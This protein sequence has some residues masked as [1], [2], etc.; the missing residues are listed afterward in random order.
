MHVRDNQQLQLTL[1]AGQAEEGCPWALCGVCTPQGALN[2]RMRGPERAHAAP[3]AADKLWSSDVE[4]R[5]SKDG[6]GAERKRDR[7]ATEGDGGG[8]GRRREEE[9][10]SACSSTSTSKKGFR[11][12]CGVLLSLLPCLSLLCMHF[13]LLFTRLCLR[14]CSR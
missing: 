4:R 6:G 1:H 8:D 12:S 13:C 2:S 3:S 5:Q 11:V 14:C 7:E 10:V 9:T